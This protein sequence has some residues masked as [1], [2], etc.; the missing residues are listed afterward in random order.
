MR[1]FLPFAALVGVALVLACQDLGLVGPD[2]LVP[3]FNKPDPITREHDHGGEDPPEPFALN[4]TINSEQLT[5]LKIPDDT[6][7]TGVMTTGSLIFEDFPLDLDFF[8]QHTGCTLLGS[9]M[10][11]LVMIRG[12]GGDLGELG[13]KFMHVDD[14]GGDPSEHSL[15]IE[16]VPEAGDLAFWSDPTM[17]RVAISRASGPWQMKSKGRNNK[18]GCKGEDDGMAGGGDDVIYRIT[19]AP[20]A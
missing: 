5:G 16:G 18:N 2:G 15:D 7:T 9:E 19:V 11:R 17:T 3:Q 6:V 4:V 10:G 13:F 14:G 20:P 1:R 8:N 12:D